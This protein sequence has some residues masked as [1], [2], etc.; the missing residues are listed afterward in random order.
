[1]VGRDQRPRR[2]VTMARLLLLTGMSLGILCLVLAARGEE[3][4]AAGPCSPNSAA[5]DAEEQQFLDLLHSWRASAG[6][7]SEP[8]Q[9]SGA[10]NQAAAWFAEFQ[11]ANGAPGGH[12]DN[13]GRTWVQRAIDCGYTGQTSGGQPYASGSGEGIFGAAGNP[14]P[15]VG[16]QAA[17]NGMIN[18]QGSQSGIHM[19]G[20]ANLPAKCYGVAVARAGNAVAWVVV[21]AQYPANLPCP[22]G[23][24][25]SGPPPSSTSSPT[26]TNTPTKTPT[27]TPTPRPALRVPQI[28]RD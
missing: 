24:G 1:M 20:T 14:T 5:V 8:M 22:A 7:S 18:Q 27:A 6:V 25:T 21:I 13:L 16:P 11:A 10:L 12:Q 26:A 2:L 4:H 15:N 28:S 9:M 17:L 23:S 19:T 3:A